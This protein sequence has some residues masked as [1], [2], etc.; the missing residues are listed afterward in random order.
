MRSIDSYVPQ[1]LRSLVLYI[2]RMYF[3]ERGKISKCIDDA[4]NVS[5]DESV[6]LQENIFRLVKRIGI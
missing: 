6:K 1:A 4:K 5:M 3:D 2:N